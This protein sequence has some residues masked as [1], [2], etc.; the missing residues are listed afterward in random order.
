MTKPSKK[1]ISPVIST[2]LLSAFVL[3][4]GGVIWAFS[5]EASTWAATDYVNETM[6]LAD[7]AN[8]RFMIEH[9]STTETGD[10]LNVWV[11][12]FGDLSIII[13]VYIEV[14]DGNNGE[15]KGIQINPMECYLIEVDFSLDPL[16]TGDYVLIK[17]IS[18]RQNYVSENFLV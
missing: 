3:V 14:D 9:I 7:V 8:E 15:V 1:G 4:V 17:I 5:V 13:D 11:F 16:V 2:I 6:D 18:R 10:K 12:N